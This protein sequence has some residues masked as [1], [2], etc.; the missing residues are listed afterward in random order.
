MPRPLAV[1]PSSMALA[2]PASAGR[3][4]AAWTKPQASGVP[5]ALASLRLLL[6]GR[7][8][9]RQGAVITLCTTSR[10]WQL[11]GSPEA[12]ATKAR[13]CLRARPV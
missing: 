12:R 10:R 9:H 1:A 11:S 13:A 8:G 6:P 4:R 3:R 2:L 5:L 7:P